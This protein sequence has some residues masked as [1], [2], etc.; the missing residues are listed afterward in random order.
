MAENAFTE[1]LDVDG[2][3]G[4]VLSVLVDVLTVTVRIIDSL[5][6]TSMAVIPK[7]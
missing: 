2:A 1:R 3:D 5:L 7:V 4:A 6:A